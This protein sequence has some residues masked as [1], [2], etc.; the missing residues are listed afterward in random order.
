M[1]MGITVLEF[2]N[3]VCFRRSGLM[4]SVSP[5]EWTFAFWRRLIQ[6]KKAKD[7]CLWWGCHSE[8]VE[9]RHLWCARRS[10]RR[11]I[12]IPNRRAED[13]DKGW[14]V[15]GIIFPWHILLYFYCQGFVLCCVKSQFDTFISLCLFN[16][17]LLEN[18]LSCSS[19]WWA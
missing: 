10:S 18:S 1:D 15:G 17:F 12:L 19:V 2:V 7:F 8:R 6:I 16:Y 14:L 9:V 3:R 13:G 4:C 11:I 5:G